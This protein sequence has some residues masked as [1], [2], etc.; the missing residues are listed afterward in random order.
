MADQSINVP[1][2]SNNHNYSNVELIVSI[3]SSNQIDAVWAGWGH[4]SENPK[5]PHLLSKKGIVFLGPTSQAMGILGDKVSSLIVAQTVNVPTLP[6]T[7]SGLKTQLTNAL[8]MEISNELFD[9]ACVL[10]AD[11][12]LN[13]SNKIGKTISILYT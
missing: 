13:K 2:G 5:L 4:A 11:D 12:G 6:W 10:S 8:T 3:A 7:G 1:G 9:R